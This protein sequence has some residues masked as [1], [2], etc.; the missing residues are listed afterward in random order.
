M[1]ELQ[2]QTPREKK[3]WIET[4]QAAVKQ[5]PEDDDEDEGGIAS[6]GQDLASQGEEERQR[7]IREAQEIKTRQLISTLREKD[8]QLASMLEDK[9]GTFCELVELLANNEDGTN[10]WILLGSE[11]GPPKYGHLV[12]HG[13]QTP[14]ARETLSQVKKKKKSH[15]PRS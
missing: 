4:I 15:V 3:I 12:E 2:C 5:C 9:M 11:T 1:Y 6:S 10:T 14:Q 13:F 8:R 7:K